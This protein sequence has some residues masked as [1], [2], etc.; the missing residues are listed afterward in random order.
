MRLSRIIL[1]L[2]SVLLATTQTFAA[3]VSFATAAVYGSG[4]IGANAIAVADVNGDG[5]PDIVVATNDGVGVLLNNA[6]GSG[7][8]ASVVDYPTGGTF[9]AGLAVVDVNGDGFPDIVVTNMCLN[10]PPACYG[11]AV[12]INNTDGTFQSPVG[13][14]SGGLETGGIA[15]GDVN[16]DGLPDLVLT[17]N[18]QEFTCAG[19]ELTL[20]LNIGGGQFGTSIELSDAKGPVTLGDMNGDGILDLITPAG[21]MLGVG[22]GT[23]GAANGQVAGGGANAIAVGDINHDGKLDVVSALPTGVAVQLGNG[24]GTLGSATYYK[25]TGGQNPLS[26]TIADFNGDNN[27]DIAVANE[28]SSLALQPPLNEVTCKGYA[29]VG[30]LPGN[31]DGTFQSVVTLN[32][33]GGLA[34]SVAVGD[35]NGDTKPDIFV[36]SACAFGGGNSVVLCTNGGTVSVLLN[37]FYAGTTTKLVSSL[38]PALVGQSVTFTATITSSSAI[39]DGSPVTFTDGGNT[40]GTSNTVS[41][42][43][44][45]T[46]SFSL[47]ARHSIVASYPGDLY[48][49]PSSAMVGE[50]INGYPT[51]TALSS[52]PNPSNYG[53]SVTFI[54]VITGTGSLTPTGTV[55]FKNGTGTI[56][57]VT[58][59]NTGT[60]TLMT[61]KLPLGTANVTA[62]YNG[63][64][65][66][67]KSTS[68]LVMQTVN[69]AQLM[70]TVTSNKNPSNPG[71][72]VRFTATITSNGS[73]PGGTV[74]FSYNGSPLGT[75][76]LASG[77]ASLTTSS[78]PAGPDLVTASFTGNADYSSASGSITQN[79][80]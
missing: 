11:V 33:F 12:L 7:T 61:T 43:A 67:A 27:P 1:I 68:N 30:V 75:I 16:G 17:S 55:T 23:F 42:V 58:L 5:Y 60:A 71:Q 53:Q 77:T 41:G 69:Q 74:T 3:S 45:W 50:Q 32:T 78:L 76:N 14:D 28:C 66:N 10:T 63:D 6:D 57:L 80:N 36:S 49:K 24:D 8:Y 79:V 48:H 18:C 72:G 13:Y 54:A 26:V 29:Y 64:S 25:K 2:A 70:I 73:I 62:Y 38:N 47:I 4:A 34:T 51:T 19:G 9:S 22:D 52:G 59:D 65:S 31:G 20:L 21:V 39:P 44:T 35:A 15:V 56:G 40:L 37:N 46:T